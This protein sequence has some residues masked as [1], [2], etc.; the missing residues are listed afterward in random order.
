MSFVFYMVALI[1][2][3]ERAIETESWFLTALFL[4]VL[5]FGVFSVG[6]TVVRAIL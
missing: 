1:L 4:V 5:G 2:A 6:D 3:A